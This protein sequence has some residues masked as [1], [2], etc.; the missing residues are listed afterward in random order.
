MSDAAQRVTTTTATRAVIARAATVGALVHAFFGWGPLR[1]P[2][3]ALAASPA[4][5]ASITGEPILTASDVRALVQRGWLERDDARAL[6]ILGPYGPRVLE[7]EG[8]HL[9][10]VRIAHIE[11]LECALG[12]VAAR[13]MGVAQFFADGL[14]RGGAVSLTVLVDGETARAL[15]RAF[16][17]HTIFPAVVRTG[18]GGGGSG[19]GQEAHM[20]FFLAGQG[21]L[22]MAYDR[23]LT[24]AHPDG[25]YSIFGNRDYH[26]S[27]FLRMTIGLHGGSPALLDIATA[28]GPAAP[29][30]PFEKRV[31]FL[32]PAIHSLYVHD[33]DVTADTSIIDRKIR[34]PPVEWREG[35]VKGAARLQELGCPAEG[36]WSGGRR[37][38]TDTSR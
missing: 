27:P 22:V 6:R 25:A 10:D 14:F 11:A 38:A 20:L 30:R 24:Y 37:V 3:M 9:P 35:Q 21:R 18:G 23:G 26:I 34:P 13:H 12:R 19:G 28:D 8:V 36:G 2:G 5:P 4:G 32:S 1:A 17:L 7:V 16:D 33:R 31:L 29:L 15:D